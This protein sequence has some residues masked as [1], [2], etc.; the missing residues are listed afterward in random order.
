MTFDL[1]ESSKYVLI[2]RWVSSRVRRN[3]ATAAIPDAGYTFEWRRGDERGV[4]PSLDSVR[5]EGSIRSRAPY[6]DRTCT[7]HGAPLPGGAA[8]TPAV[9]SIGSG[10]GELSA[11]S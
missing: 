6:L 8:R 7:A 5:C 1:A 3:S 2:V 10:C 4:A 9:S 11:A